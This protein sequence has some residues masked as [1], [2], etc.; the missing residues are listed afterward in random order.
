MDAHTRERAARVQL[1]LFDVDGILTDGTL[2]IGAGGEL[3]KAFNVRDGLGLKM[4][5][6][7]GIEVGLLSSRRSTIVDA[8]AAEL[9]IALVVQGAANKCAV[10]QDLLAERGVSAERC[11]FMGDDF[12][13][14]R[15]MSSCG[16]AATVPEA[17]GA[18]R[19]RAHY[20]STA[21][22]GRGAAREVCELILAAQ[23]RMEEALGRYLPEGRLP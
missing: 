23:G 14:L 20:V 17:S 11:G 21:A 13:D 3:M 4:L 22:G 18:V 12:P 15:V 1:M 16:F 7:C 2:Y 19:A 10:F 5:R 6:E 9:G 8:R